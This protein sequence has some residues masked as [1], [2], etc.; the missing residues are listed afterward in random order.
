MPTPTVPRVTAVKRTGIFG[1]PEVHEQADVD[2]FSD[3]EEDETAEL[4]RELEKIKRERAEQ[5]EKE[6]C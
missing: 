1:M 6:V 2:R 5:K 4:L 3:D